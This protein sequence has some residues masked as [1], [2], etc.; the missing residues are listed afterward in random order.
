MNG[1]CRCRNAPVAPR[2]LRCASRCKRAARYDARAWSPPSS[3]RRRWVV[4]A[5]AATAAAAPSSAAAT[6][7]AAAAAATAAATP[8]RA[9]ATSR[10]C[11]SRTSRALRTSIPTSSTAGAS[12]SIRKASSGSAP[13]ARR[14]R[15]CTTATACRNRWW[16]RFLPARPG[17]RRPPV[18]SST[19]RRTSA[20]P[21]AARPMRARSSSPAWPGRSPPGHPTSTSTT[22]SPFSTAPPRTRCTPA[23]HWRTAAAPTCSTPPTSATVLS[24]ASTPISRSS[25][26]G[27]PTRPCLRATHRSASRRS[28]VTSMS[29]TRS[30]T[31]TDATPSRAQ[32]LGIVNV[33]DASGRCCVALLPAGR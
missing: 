26:L 13:P 29:P 15:L 3:S 22:Q 28:A 23:L 5:A 4:A 14:H 27:S 33:F 16:W 21:R 32:G 11:S 30:A 10:A 20:S 18:S 2:R 8:P 1:S 7:P 24:M 9:P 12:P 17:R 19:A 31:R 6:T 25:R